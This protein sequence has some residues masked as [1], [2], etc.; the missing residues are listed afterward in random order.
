MG[1]PCDDATVDRVHDRT[2]LKAMAAN[3]SK[4]DDHFV[5]GKL[6]KQMG[7]PDDAKHLASK[8]RSGTVGAKKTLP[9]PVTAMLE[10]RWQNT[11]KRRT[12]LGSYAELRAA[13]A[14][15]HGSA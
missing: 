14:L 4:Y 10:A 13:V 12:G 15:S 2:T 1:V 6:K 7:F 3:Q 8:V 5:F 9:K 11:M